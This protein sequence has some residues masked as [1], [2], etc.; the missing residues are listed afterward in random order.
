MRSRIKHGTN[1]V[2]HRQIFTL[3]PLSIGSPTSECV[4]RYELDA[5]TATNLDT[6]LADSQ[7]HNIHQNHVYR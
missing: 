3:V 5:L 6:E 4:G 2:K 7:F 1:Y